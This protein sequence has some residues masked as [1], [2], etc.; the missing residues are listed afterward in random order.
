MARLSCA[1]GSLVGRC[2]LAEAL[3][4]G[5]ADGEPLVLRCPRF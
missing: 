3:R 5:D 2:A 4:L 1:T